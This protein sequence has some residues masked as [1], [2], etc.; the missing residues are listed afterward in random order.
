MNLVKDGAAV[1]NSLLSYLK[2]FRFGGR[3]RQ[4]LTADYTVKHLSFSTIGQVS[5]ENMGEAVGIS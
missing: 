1:V 5:F 4:H 2:Y 3:L